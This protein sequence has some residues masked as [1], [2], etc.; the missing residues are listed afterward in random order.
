MAFENLLETNAIWRQYMRLFTSFEAGLNFYKYQRGWEVWQKY[1]HLF[2]I[3]KYVFVQQGDLDIPEMTTIFL[4]NKKAMLSTINRHFKEFRKVL[5][6]DFNLSKI[7]GSFSKKTNT[8]DKNI[9]HHPALL[10]ILLGYGKRNSW[11]YWEIGELRMQAK[12]NQSINCKL[13]NAQATFAPIFKEPYPEL[14]R[15]IF[16]PMF[17]CDQKTEKNKKLRKKYQQQRIDIDRKYQGNDF[18][19]VTLMKLTKKNIK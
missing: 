11:R 10:G 8:F 17:M 1:K 13:V 14:G 3:E 4:V 16:L 7:M 5:G 18:L 19:E 6:K 2:P 12:T 9:K 15:P